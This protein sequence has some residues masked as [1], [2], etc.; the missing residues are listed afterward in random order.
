[1]EIFKFVFT[2]GPCAGKTT[3]IDKVKELLEEDNYYVVVVP[4]TASE[5][6]SKGI[7]PDNDKKH[8]LRFQELVLETQTRKE[9]VAEE[10]CELI[11]NENLKFIKDKKGIVILYDRGIP[12]NR[13]YLT[14][15]N[16]NKMLKKYN[17]NE[18]AIIDK[19]DMVINL[20]SLATTN[21]ELYC[22]DEVRYE[23]SSEAAYRDLLTSSAW[24]L[25]RDFKMIKPTEKIE[26]KI[27]QVYSIISDKLNKKHHNSFS[28]Y[29][30][31]DTNSSFYGFNT[32]N[33]RKM[34]IQQFQLE[35]LYNS[36]LTLEKREYE[37]N[38]SYILKK[39][40]LTIDGILSESK[41]ISKKEFDYIMRNNFL[42]DI[43]EKEIIN[44][45][46]KGNFYSISKENGTYK[47]YTDDNNINILPKNI[48][49]KEEKT[50]QK[51]II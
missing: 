27:L 19:Y 34:K 2:G 43:K 39:E 1:M 29:E 22:L 24:S 35:T 16:Y 7:I 48:K 32:D 50:L 40:R 5:L 38:I 26:E 45:I 9:I 51:K 11:K 14:H 3:I 31:D 25:H 47:L 49:L 10:Y 28:E 30:L 46:D 15:D 4:E 13:A 33:S 41:S 6:I 42:S 18:L 36:Y 8:T 21:P 37:D 20:V 23:D 17:F 12:D 44:I